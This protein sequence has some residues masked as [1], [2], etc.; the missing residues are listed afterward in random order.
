MVAA[1]KTALW[2]SAVYKS[3]LY[4]WNKYYYHISITTSTCILVPAYWKPYLLWF[5]I[6]YESNL[7]FLYTLLQSMVYHR[8]KRSQSGLEYSVSSWTYTVLKYLYLVN[9]GGCKW[10]D[11][12]FRFNDSCCMFM[13]HFFKLLSNTN[14]LIPHS[15]FVQKAIS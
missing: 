3:I 7:G 5:R 15:T 2:F 13:F 9:S 12:L 6:E 4:L 1:R 8:T 10:A 11:I 14:N